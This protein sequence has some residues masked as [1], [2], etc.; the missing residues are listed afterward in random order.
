MSWSWVVLASSSSHRHHLLFVYSK[1]KG[2]TKDDCDS[3]HMVRFRWNNL[4]CARYLF[5]IGF[6]NG[7]IS[8]IAYFLPHTFVII[9]GHI[10]YSQL[11]ATFRL[12]HA[13]EDL[14]KL[15]TYD[16][17]KGYAWTVKDIGAPTPATAMRTTEERHRID[18]ERRRLISSFEFV[19][20]KFLPST[21][22]QTAATLA[23]TAIKRSADETSATSAIVDEP[24]LKKQKLT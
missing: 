19:Q 18:D 13:F 2:F 3:W 17:Y 12:R 6:A 23:S 20:R 10:P 8:K 7:T 24:S 1:Q 5:C 15:V 16:P 4:S 9:T 11:K 21:L 14:T 22:P